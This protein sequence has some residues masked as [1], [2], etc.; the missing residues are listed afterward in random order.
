M[1]KRHTHHTGSPGVR[2]RDKRQTAARLTNGSH[3]EILYGAKELLSIYY[4]VINSNI[5]QHEIVYL[6]TAPVKRCNRK[7]V[8]LLWVFFII[9]LKIH[10]LYTIVQ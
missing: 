2:S 8:Y 4:S 3:G 6:T 7:Q 5:F 1:K 9:Q 10:D